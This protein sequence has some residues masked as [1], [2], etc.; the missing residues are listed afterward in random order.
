MYTKHDGISSQNWRETALLAGEQYVAAMH[1]HPS[2]LEKRAAT[3][4]KNEPGK[5]LLHGA[6]VLVSC[7]PHPVQTL[8]L[9][10]LTLQLEQSRQVRS[11]AEVAVP[12]TQGPE[13]TESCMLKSEL[14][15]L[16]A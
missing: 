4:M 3:L 5:H 10:S 2:K 8:V 12:S 1:T 7:R 6:Q 16:K 11:S 9:Y 13:L 14:Q 15:I